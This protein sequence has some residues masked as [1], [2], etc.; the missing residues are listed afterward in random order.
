MVIYKSC[1]RQIQHLRVDMSALRNP[2]RVVGLWYLLVVIIG[3]LRLIYIPKKLFVSGN[4]AATVSNIATH[5]WLFRS[6][7]VS[8]LIGTL[9]LI[10][11]TLAFYRLFA[12]VD[13][14]LAALVVI[15]GGVMPAAISFIGIVCDFGALMAVRETDFLLVFDK[16]Q[17][18][19]LVMLFL[20]LGNHQNTAVEILWGA[21]LLPLSV[22]V[23]K[24]HF[25]P[26]FIGLW[27]AINGFAYMITSLTGTLLPQYQAKVFSLSFPAL[28]GEIV[29]TLWLLI[30]GAEPQVI[31]A[32]P[33][34]AAVP[35]ARPD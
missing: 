25:L 22:L 20:S 19:S 29:L 28:L 35:S 33:R 5:E 8:N 15:V 26:R 3:P 1:T 14:N 27:L 4:A 18:D 12:G 13:R 24:S 11:V 31:I 16:A 7:I 34:L 17:R 9:V 10:L 6:G 23:Y 2:G 32:E 30:K 21:W